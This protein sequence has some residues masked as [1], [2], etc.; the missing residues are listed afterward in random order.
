MLTVDRQLKFRKRRVSTFS[1]PV[2]GSSTRT[3]PIYKPYSLVVAH[4][5]IIFH[6]HRREK[7]T[8]TH[9]ELHLLPCG[10]QSRKT[11]QKYS[12]SRSLLHTQ[13]YFSLKPSHSLTRTS[14]NAV[15]HP[16]IRPLRVRV[17]HNYNPCRPTVM[18]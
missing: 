14:S 5:I 12:L 10:H 9:K 11:K 16:V 2:C 8:N 13:I 4:H 7:N 15:P 3:A 18:T 1:V 6:L 17:H